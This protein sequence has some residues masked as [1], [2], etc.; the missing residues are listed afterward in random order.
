MNDVTYGGVGGKTPQDKQST[1]SG[2]HEEG[3]QV[4]G[5]PAGCQPQGQA[6]GN[7]KNQKSPARSSQEESHKN[8]LT[9]SSTDGKGQTAPKFERGSA[10]AEQPNNAESRNGIRILEKRGD[11]KA[12]DFTHGQTM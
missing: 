2:E 5:V 6:D 7:R 11:A 3:E 12:L 10:D 9:G 4:D 1:E 8:H